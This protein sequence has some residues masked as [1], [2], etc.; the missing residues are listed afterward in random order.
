MKFLPCKTGVGPDGFTGEERSCLLQEGQQRALVG[1]FHGVAAQQ[2]QTVD[3]IGRKETEHLP[4][5]LLREGLPIG[6]RPG[7]RLEASRAAVGAAGYEQA[8]PYARAV[9]DIAV[10]DGAEV[11]H[12][13]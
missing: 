9:G 4:G 5:G 3:V 7:F 8:H 13:R 2:G 1:G 12:Y 6:E 10:L 11:H